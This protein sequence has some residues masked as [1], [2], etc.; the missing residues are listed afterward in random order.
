[1]FNKSNKEAYNA[2][3]PKKL[4]LVKRG[5][6][7]LPSDDI[8]LYEGQITTAEDAA[9]AQRALNEALAARERRAVERER[10]RRAVVEREQRAR[11]AS[12]MNDVDAVDGEFSS[13]VAVPRGS[14]KPVGRGR[15]GRGR[16]SRRS[17][18]RASRR[19][20]GRTNRRNRGRGQ[21]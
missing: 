20:R 17:R 5:G 7:A 11:F 16:A 21:R 4:P 3:I 13:L 12:M 9:V 14:F 2:F 19:G 10:E 18:G 8:G 6:R 1:M 15:R